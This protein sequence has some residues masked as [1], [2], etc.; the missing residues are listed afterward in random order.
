MP[1]DIDES[2]VPSAIVE[3]RAALEHG[4][5]EAEAMAAAVERIRYDVLRM[6]ALICE[7]RAQH[8]DLSDDQRLACRDCAKDIKAL[9]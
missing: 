8:T 1:M 5:S 6:A 9:F 7:M 2:L 4:Q 3:Y